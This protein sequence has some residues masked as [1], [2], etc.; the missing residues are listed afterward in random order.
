MTAGAA[1]PLDGGGTSEAS[2]P[3]VPEGLLGALLD[4]WGRGTTILTNVLR[5][6]PPGG[7][8]A[9]ALPGSP[10]VAAQFTH[11]RD[12]RLFFVSQT[13]PEVAGAPPDL[14]RSEGDDWRAER[15]PDRIAAMLADSAHAVREAV[16][17]RVEAG[18]ALRG[19]HVAYDHPVLLLQ[20]LLWHEGYH[21]GQIMLALKAAGCPLSDGEVEP[22]IWGV[23]RREW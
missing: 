12:T 5:A 23:W 7:L 17:H 3:R 16:R 19:A 21:V 20:H 18:D 6:L 9:R 4:A 14:F 15:D 13:A 10:T 11:V 8:D 22:V 2:D 1:R